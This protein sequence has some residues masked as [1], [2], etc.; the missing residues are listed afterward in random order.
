MQ[1]LDSALFHTARFPLDPPSCCWVNSPWVAEES[2][3]T[4][5]CPICLLLQS[6]KDIWVA[7]RLGPS[8]VKL[9]WTLMFRI[10][11]EHKFSFLWAKWRKR[12]MSM[13]GRGCSHVLFLRRLPN[14]FSRVAGPFRISPA[15]CMRKTLLP[16]QCTFC[17]F[18]LL[19]LFFTLAFLTG[20][21]WYFM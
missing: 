1:T 3:K 8:R 21:W 13:L 20:V 10:L 4:W 14:W 17:R 16:N 18:W 5:M 15:M 19:N 12:S 9:L 7:P 6:L 2:L 11:Y